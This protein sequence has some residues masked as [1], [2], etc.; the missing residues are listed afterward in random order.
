MSGCIV[1]LLALALAVF[2]LLSVLRQGG[3]LVA[4]GVA[5]GV[6]MSLLAT[7]ALGQFLFETAPLEPEI[8]VLA[9]FL[10]AAIGLLACLFPGLR[11]SRLDPR[12]ALNSE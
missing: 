9:V 10:L 3:R 12:E 1:P 7:R 5:L 4:T 8:F 6:G 11:A 2:V